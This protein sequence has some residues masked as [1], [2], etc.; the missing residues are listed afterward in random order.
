MS[1]KN[2]KLAKAGSGGVAAEVFYQW[3]QKYCENEINIRNNGE[4]Q[5]AA[6]AQ[7]RPY[8]HLSELCW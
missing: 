1:V 6:Y 7:T 5:V 4:N 3:N 8:V 2:G